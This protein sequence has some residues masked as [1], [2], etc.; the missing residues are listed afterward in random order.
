MR[1][2]APKTTPSK[3]DRL[4][5]RALRIS[6]KRAAMATREASA[7]GLARPETVAP[8]TLRA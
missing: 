6:T 1:I 2:A 8:T 3:L 7:S 5:I 4:L